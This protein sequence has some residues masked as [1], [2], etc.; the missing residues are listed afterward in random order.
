[1]TERGF[2]LVL[3]AA[4]FGILIYAVGWL[5]AL[6]VFFAFWASNM[7]MRRW[8][9]CMLLRGKAAGEVDE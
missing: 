5:A 7:D 6:G 3:W 8:V 1:M 2:A 4:S 9:Y